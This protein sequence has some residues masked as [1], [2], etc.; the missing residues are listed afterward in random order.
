MTQAA[1][2]VIVV[3]AG[4]AGLHAAFKTA[5][6]YHTALVVDK[7]QKFGRIFYT[8]EIWNLP[9]VEGSIRGTDLLKRQ[10]RQIEAYEATK[11]RRFVTF[12]MGHEATRVERREAGDEVEYT[13]E[14]RDVKTGAAKKVS[15]KNLVL[16]TGVVDR[17]PVF[18]KARGRRI[19]PVLPYANKGLSEY[20]LLCDGHALSGRKWRSSDAGASPPSSPAC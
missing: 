7:G 15:G 19:D 16:A 4:P 20:C 14:L 3:G 2:D 11:G 12:L 17:Q 13:L 6:L 9:G 18:D 1:Y 5:L 10:R 8:P